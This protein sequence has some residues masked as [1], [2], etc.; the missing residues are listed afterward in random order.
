MV[1]VFGTVGVPPTIAT[2]PP[3]TRSLPEASRAMVMLLSPA[4]P[5]TVSTPWLKAAVTEAAP[6][7]PGA[8]SAAPSATNASRSA[9][10]VCRADGVVRKRF[11]NILILPNPF[12]CRSDCPGR[13][14]RRRGALALL[15]AAHLVVVAGRG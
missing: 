6:A 14:V 5:L 1:A 8:T 12:L 4:V 7:A 10:R 11:V 3:L 9:S 13:S 15:L 2:A